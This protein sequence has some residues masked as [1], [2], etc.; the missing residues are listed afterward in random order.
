[1]K[2]LIFT[3]AVL[4]TLSL[5]SCE[6]MIVTSN[7]TIDLA[8]KATLSGDVL[9]ELN[10]QSSGLEAV[11]AGT[12]LLVEVNYS[13]INPASVGKWMDT[14]QVGADG[15][16]MVQVPTDANGVNVSIMP[17]AF[18]ADQTQIYGSMI[19]KVSKTYS[20]TAA[21]VK[22][23]AQGQ[24]IISDINYD[25]LTAPPS[26]IEKVRITGTFTANLN[27]EL[28]GNENVPNQTVVNFFNSSW[29]DSAVVTNGKYS[30]LVPKGVALT[31]KSKFT[32]SKK[33][34]NLT[35]SSYSNLNYEYKF[36]ALKTF[37]TMDEVVNLI[38][39]N[40]GEGDDLTVHPIVSGVSG[41]CTA[42]LD[43]SLNGFENMPN[44]TTIKLWTTTTPI[45]GVTTTVSSGRYLISAPKN[46]TV[47]WSTKFN[48]VKKVGMIDPLSS[49]TVYVNEDYE[50]NM[51]GSTTFTDDVEAYNI[52]ASTG[53]SVNPNYTISGKAL[54]E[55]DDTSAGLENIPNNTVIRFYYPNSTGSTKNVIVSNGNYTIDIPK[56]RSVTYSGTFV[57]SKKVAG[58]TTSKTFTIAGSLNADGTKTVDVIATTNL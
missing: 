49:N 1:M 48:A 8:P 35:T 58:V 26:F 37:N 46:Q 10:L 44:A 33:V 7:Q 31:L 38:A 11:P 13:D 30:I 32:Y 56:G 57:A 29:K 9:A 15:K 50:Y 43:E 3:V 39:A 23:I 24:S 14:I 51:N 34:W 12:Q 41:T 36:D 16:Y 17:F 20:V 47:Y 53:T 2:K 25:K 4:A 45:W 5:T 6:E 21:T 27:Q 22:A 54:V 40:S 55:L 28:G 18:V 42:D 52:S 19:A